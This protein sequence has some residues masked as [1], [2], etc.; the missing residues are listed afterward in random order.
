MTDPDRRATGAALDPGFWE[1]VLAHGAAL[2]GGRR[3]DDM[4]VE[5]VEMLGDLDP[6]LRDDLALTVLLRWIGAGVYDDLLP[7]MGDGISEGLRPGLG[8]DGTPSVLRRSFSARVLAAVIDRDNVLHGMHREAVL[9]WGDRGLSWLV[10]E[11]DLRGHVPGAGRAHAL[12]HAGDLVRALAQ[13]RHL[14]GE[15]LGV[16]LDTLADRLLRPTAHGFAGLEADQLAYA[17]MTVLH[18]D[19]VDTGTVQGWIHRLAAGWGPSST[20]SVRTLAGPVPAQV[21]NTVAFTRALHLQLL[22]GVRS[23]RG[24]PAFEGPPPARVEVL[25]TLQAV[26]RTSGPHFE[27]SRTIPGTR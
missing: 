26:L 27:P 21:R 4:T 1:D 11:R 8:E 10:A 7:A 15:G 16:L 13:S 25:A 18:R 12:E 3:L 19:A 17:A 22:L 5:L 23:P 20:N 24:G 14:Q 6:H 2:P 9:R